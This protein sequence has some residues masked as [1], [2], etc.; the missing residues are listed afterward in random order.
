MNDSDSPRPKNV[1][2]PS[3]PDRESENA[4]LHASPTPRTTAESESSLPPELTGPAR[5]RWNAK[6]SPGSNLGETSKV[7][8]DAH[9]AVRA[10]EFTVNVSL[11]AQSGITVLF[12]P[13]GAGKSLTLATIAGLRRPD[14]GTIT[15]NNRLVA[16]AS[17][18]FHMRTQDRNLGVV[19]QDSLL[20]PHRNVRDNVALAVR[21]GS[22]TERRARAIELLAT[23]GASNLADAAPSRL[24]GGER[25]R[26]ALARALAG[27]PHALLLDEPFSALDYATRQILRT[28]LRSLVDTTAIPTLLVTHD[29][30]EAAE[31][32]DHTVMYLD[33][34]TSMQQSGFPIQLANRS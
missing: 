29:L 8:I 27:N 10:G 15:I 17:T 32:A 18:G 26:I 22:R 4:G 20:L 12:G 7:A 23:V 13:S 1:C 11:R 30:D 14:S 24:S 31:L 9:F 6:E 16:D 28:L 34:S 2:N 21:S 3:S 19:F 25:Q 5:E 33:G